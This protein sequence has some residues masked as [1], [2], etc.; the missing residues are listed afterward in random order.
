[1][2]VY[3]TEVVELAAYWVPRAAPASRVCTTTTWTPESMTTT[4]T[5]VADFL[6]QH[7][8]ERYAA[9]FDEE[10]GTRSCSS[11]ISP[12][13]TLCSSSPTSR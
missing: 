9:A 12:R 5:T 2:V 3:N 6:S 8:L 4:A 10:A 1:M 7:E 13:R 11:R